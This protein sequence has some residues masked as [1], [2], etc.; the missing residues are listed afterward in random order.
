MTHDLLSANAAPPCSQVPMDIPRMPSPSPAC[1]APVT[2][3]P[4]TPGWITFTRMASRAFWPTNTAVA[5]GGAFSDRQQL[6]QEIEE[7]LHQGPQPL[8]SPPPTTAPHTVPSRWT[9]D[10]IRASFDGLA[11]YTRSG[12]WRLLNR[13]GLRL[14]SA[15]V[16]QFSP[17]PEY[18][19]KLT[20]LEMAL[21]EARRYP[22]SVVAVF[23]DE[24]GFSR[25]PDPGPDWRGAPPVA[26]RRG[27]KNKLWRLIG[28]LNPL[29]GQ[30]NYLD[31]YIVGRAKVINFHELLVEAYPQARRLYVIQDNWSIHSHED[32]QEALQRWPQVTPVWLPTY[33]PW[34]NPI[35]KLWRWL[36]QDVL[37]FHRWADD[38]DTLLG[39]VRGFLELFAHGSQRLLEYVGLLGNGRLARMVHGP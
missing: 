8:P 31:A 14:R 32:V 10:W 23:L 12:V 33:A 13:L 19:S 38:W 1:S 3:I 16:Q 37:K 27:A 25:W 39:R 29:T 18:A 4:S 21:W 2:P 24:M 34:L 26:D 35:E 7:R 5:V 20:D 30:V 36:R 28:A 15:Q 9:L 6:K 22:R 11:G 17:D